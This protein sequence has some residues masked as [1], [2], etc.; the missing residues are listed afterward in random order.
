MKIYT[1]NFRSIAKQ[2]SFIAF[3]FLLTT[4]CKKESEEI[5]PSPET[6]IMTDIDG[7]VYKTIKIGNQWWMAENLK[8]KKYRNGYLI[9]E[10]NDSTDWC[11]RTSGA[12][13]AYN[14]NSDNAKTYGLLYNWFVISDTA[15]IAPEGWHIPTDDEWKELEKQTGMSASEAEKSGWRGTHEGEKLKIA[16]TE[17]WSSYTD[18]WPTNESG[19][20]ALGGS[21]RVFNSEMGFPGLKQTGFWWTRS[22]NDNL[23]C[24][25]YLDYKN[26]NVFR[27]RG[28][29]N[30]GFSIRCVKD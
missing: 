11:D 10:I 2:I 1:S 25:R 5:L 22:E 17:G 18:V 14:F 15:T 6:G 30:Y 27:G 24:Y 29:K 4:G 3:L 16:G 7:N 19:F 20:T 9:P 8:V 12:C 26:A 21:C 23:A 13:C 28:S